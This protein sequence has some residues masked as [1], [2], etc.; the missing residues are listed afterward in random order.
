LNVSRLTDPSAQAAQAARTA[1]TVT[2]ERCGGTEINEW[3]VVLSK[4]S[5]DGK[6]RFRRWQVHAGSVA[7]TALAPRVT[8][9]GRVR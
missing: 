4:R 6:L 5:G 8:D 3:R 9:R 1:Q 7:R 2:R